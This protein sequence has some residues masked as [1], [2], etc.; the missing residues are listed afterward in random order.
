MIIIELLKTKLRMNQRIHRQKKKS[1]YYIVNEILTNISNYARHR[2]TMIINI[3]MFL[4]LFLILFTFKT[5]A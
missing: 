5:V 4:F 3:F 2:H 1:H